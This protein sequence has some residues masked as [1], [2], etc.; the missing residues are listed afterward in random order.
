MD[1]HKKSIETAIELIKNGEISREVAE[2]IFPELCESEDERIR[3]KLIQFL[4]AVK[5]IS[6]A[7][8]STWYVREEDAGMCDSFILY[9]ERQKEKKPTS[10]NE[11]YNPDEYE[12]VMEGN[13]TSLKR[14]EQN[15]AWSEE[16]EKIR[17]SLLRDYE[18]AM[19]SSG[20]VWGEDFKKKHNWL[21]SLPERFNLQPKQEWSEEDEE[22]LKELI[23]YFDGVPL[24]HTEKAIKDWLKHCLKFRRPSWKPSEEQMEA[25][26]NSTA[27]TEEQRE[28][29][30]SLVQ[31]L[32][33][34]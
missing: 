25:L 34:L 19:Q 26:E 10:F 31:D 9:L 6:E 11:P 18:Y 24:E 14:K 1:N 28:A 7:G 32:R 8:R 17:Q 3:K 4:T 16:D 5:N 21:K 30:H 20:T 33:K 13:A 27:L 29:L 23:D 2:K 22:Y 15:P 12:V